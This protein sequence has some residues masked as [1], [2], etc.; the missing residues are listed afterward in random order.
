MMR[1]KMNIR[2]SIKINFCGGCPTSVKFPSVGTALV[3]SEKSIVKT[4]VATLALDK[5]EIDKSTLAENSLDY[6]NTRYHSRP[7]KL[8]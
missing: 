6:H 8:V 7:R 3:L 1:M 5:P 2:I 4:K